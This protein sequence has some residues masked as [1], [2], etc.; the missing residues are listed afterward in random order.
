MKRDCKLSLQ[1]VL[2][3]IWFFVHMKCTIRTTARE[4]QHSTS[5][6]VQWFNKCRSVCTSIIE[7]EPLFVGTRENPIQ[8]DE[9]YFIGKRKYAKKRLL[10]G[11]RPQHDIFDGDGEVEISGWCEDEIEEKNLRFGRDCNEWRWVLRIYYSKTKTR[12]IRLKDRT[13]DF[14]LDV[15]REYVREG[16]LRWT[17]EFESYKCLPKNIYQHQSVNHKKNYVDPITGAHTQGVERSWVDSKSWYRSSR[18][19]R[20]LLQS[21]LHETAWRRLR[22]PQKVAETLVSSFIA[23]IGS[24]YSLW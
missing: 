22:T 24:C 3:L 4:T 11:D 12:F 13:S 9:N 7:Q 14:I 6:A 21:H 1:S 20:T 5:T 18:G 19:N 10:P 15:L 16:S 2:E 23:V 8:V 17:D